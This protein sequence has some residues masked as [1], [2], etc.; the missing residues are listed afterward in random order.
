MWFAAVGEEAEAMGMG[1]FP[2][3]SFVII[4]FQSL[5]Q[6]IDLPIHTNNEPRLH[7]LVPSP[8]GPIGGSID[9]PVFFLAQPPVDGGAACA[10][11]MVK[12]ENAAFG[13]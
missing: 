11:D 8:I 2:M 4:F 12:E 6:F 10:G 13:R 1:D 5:L 9:I 3:S 7:S